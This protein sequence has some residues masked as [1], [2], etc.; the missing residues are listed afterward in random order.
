MGRN[1]DLRKRIA[2][3][4]EIIEKHEIRIRS[5]LAKDRPNESE[6]ASWHREIKVWNETVARLTRRLKRGW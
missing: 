1:E 2:G 5:E 3:Y 6:I 4:R